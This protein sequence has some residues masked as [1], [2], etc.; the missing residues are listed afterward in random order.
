MGLADLKKNSTQSSAQRSGQRPLQ[1]SLDALIE[2]FID[3][4]THYAAGQSEQVQRMAQVIELETGFSGLFDKED[5]PVKAQQKVVPKGNMPY[6]KATFTLSESAIAHLAELASDCDI[7]KSKLI[8][9][10][11]EHHYSLSDAERSQKER[12]ILVD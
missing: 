10:L 11:I 4:A 7:A 12:S 5:T 1:M 8:R 3:D 9:F 2:D 6:R